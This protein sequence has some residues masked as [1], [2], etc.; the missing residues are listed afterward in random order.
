MIMF[1]I[2]VES[3][4]SAES[5]AIANEDAEARALPFRPNT[6]YVIQ[7]LLRVLASV[8]MG[9][10]QSRCRYFAS[11][12]QRKQFGNVLAQKRT[13]QEALGMQHYRK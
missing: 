3:D 13:Q 1:G 2:S 8:G 7:I 6:L 10:A 12:N 11:A 4:P 5:F 9:N